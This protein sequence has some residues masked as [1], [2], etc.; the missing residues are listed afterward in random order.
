MLLL[1]TDRLQIV[2]PQAINARQLYE[3]HHRNTDHFAQGG[4]TLPATLDECQRRLA[5]E[6]RVWGLDMGYRYYGLLEGDPILDIGLSNIVRGVF[7]AAHLGYRSHQDYQGQGYMIEALQS[8][9]EH[10]FGPL[11]LHR[12]MANYQPWNKAS[13][14]ILGKLGFV[15][16]GMA[17]D[18][19][20]I[21]G[22]WR[23]H[24][25]TALIN[26][27]WKPKP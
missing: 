24:I 1:E 21:D 20:F 15:E 23:D 10:A 3:Y 27:D 12:I 13:G 22:A 2:D 4:G 26:P 11:N 17:K 25:L 6:K 16:E 14:H 19:L 5:N 7:Q 18:Y 8:V 9:I